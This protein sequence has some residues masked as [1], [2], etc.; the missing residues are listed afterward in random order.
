MRFPNIKR[1]LSKKGKAVSNVEHVSETNRLAKVPAHF[2][3]KLRPAKVQDYIPWLE[4]HIANGGRPTHEYD[5]PFPRWGWFVA[6]DDIEPVA[7]YGAQSISIIVP[8]GISVGAGD[9]GHCE[10]FFMDDFTSNSIVP[11]FLDTGYHELYQEKARDDIPSILEQKEYDDSLHCLDRM[12]ECAEC[13]GYI[14]LD[15]SEEGKG[16][17]KSGGCM[18]KSKAEFER[19]WRNGKCADFSQ[20]EGGALTINASEIMANIARANNVTE[21]IDLSNAPLPERQNP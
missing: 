2:T 10:L 11:I 7:L 5:Y 13:D 16:I 4:G 17:K 12:G 3:G 8:P 19:H 6:I 14:F 1:Y 15:E 9:W 18:R 20:R 21:C